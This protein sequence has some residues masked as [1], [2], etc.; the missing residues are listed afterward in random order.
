LSG[1]HLQEYGRLWNMDSYPYP[2]Y[3]LTSTTRVSSTLS[4]TRENTFLSWFF[5]FIWFV[6]TQ[7]PGSWLWC[8]LKSCLECP[9]E[10][11]ELY[12]MIL[13]A[14]SV[15]IFLKNHQKTEKITVFGP[16]MW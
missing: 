16:Y 7:I 5:A 11:S 3:T 4:C 13:G 9:W 10:C 15:K 1:M 6:V 2:C 12:L 8:K 14:F